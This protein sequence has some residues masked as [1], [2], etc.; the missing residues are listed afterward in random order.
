M[1]DICLFEDDFSLFPLGPFPFDSE[2]SAM[3]EYHYYPES[4]FTGKWYDPIT[5]FDYKGPT[6]L[7][8]QPFLNGTRIMEQMRI[9]KPKAKGAIP[10]LVA[11]DGDW[12]DY[13]LVAKLRAL[14]SEQICGVLFRYQTS[15][16]HYGLFLVS[17][18]LELHRV[19][20]LERTVLCRVDVLWSCDTFQ[21]LTVQVEG[22][23]ITASLDGKPLLHYSDGQYQ[24]GCI[25][26]CA[27]MPTQ[28]ASVAV[29]ATAAVVSRLQ[30]K[31]A[32]E[33]SELALLKLSHAQPRLW[34]V[35]DLKDF[36]AGRQ[37]RFGHLT[38]TDELFF[39]MCQHQRRVYK[40]RYPFISCMTAVSLVT[41][42]VLWQIG[43]SRDSEDVIQITT[44]LPFQI[45][46]IDNDGVDEVI[47]SWD[48]QLFILDGRTGEI[49]KSI[50]TPEN[51]EPVES[52]CGVE[53]GHHAFKRLNIDAIRIVNVSGK[54]R[55][56]DILIKD[57]YSRLWVFNDKLELLWKFSHNNTGHFPYAYDFDGD[58]CDELFSCYN[59]IDSKGNLVWELPVEI[60]HTDEIV[61]GKIDPDK[62]EMLAI[63]SGW[64]GFMLVDKQ[65]SILFR[66]INGHG[67]RISVGT[68]CPDRAGL[69]ICTTTFWG[70][71]GI[72]YL[73]D[74]KGHELW[75]K[76]MRCN[77]NI[78]AP[79]NWDGNGVDLL[80]LNGNTMNGGMLEGSGNV[81]V[82]FPDDG[83]PDLCAEVVD[84]TGDRRDEIVL[85]DRKRMYIY[86]QDQDISP[87]GMEYAP[88]KY[89]LYNSS[90][91]RGEYCFPHWEKAR[92]QK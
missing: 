10:T 30:E 84:C 32:K 82:R 55:P 59:M 68:Y 53:F 2:H 20:K 77:G 71:Q 7:V 45:Y 38:G 56:S 26:L 34:N 23:L 46:D 31:R 33:A 24:T 35:I 64:E 14:S 54:E 27:C 62:E 91:Y 11:G 21:E 86:T 16:M 79:V 40:D 76:E 58:G 41:G 12:S 60:D 69:Q 49:K 87:Q 22:P 78:I 9:E 90:N 89:P 15:M 61:I 74:C 8:S 51:V 63:V 13:T 39:V 6:W 4:G 85:W 37:I 5:N 80:L 48:F 88:H 75:H 52:L 92:E 47:A 25:A 1:S 83:H 66:D 65:G 18:G 3:G 19:A 67:Q 73:Y 43:E 50:P 28:Y 81:V 36:G 44:D 29:T 72:L 42:D 17:G 70:S 57:R